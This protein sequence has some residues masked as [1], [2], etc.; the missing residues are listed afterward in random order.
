AGLDSVLTEL[1]RR[2]MRLCRAEC[3]GILLWDQEV[4]RLRVEVCVGQT[5][6][7]GD[8]GTSRCRR[9]MLCWP[10][11]DALVGGVLAQRRP[12][13]VEDVRTVRPSALSDVQSII[14]APMLLDD[15][16]FGV[17]SL[18]HSRARAF[19]RAHLSLLVSLAT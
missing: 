17:L 6:H 19:T 5:M 8:V 15:R 10:S 13:L 11:G 9:C 3:A 12:M 4:D 14:A 7:Q 16:P 1:G 2:I 18:G